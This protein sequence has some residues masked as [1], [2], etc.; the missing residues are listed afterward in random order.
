MDTTETYR[1][2][3]DCPEIQSHQPKII[4]SPYGYVPKDGEL[5]SFFYMNGDIELLHYDNDTSCMMIGGYRDEDAESI[6]L[7]R[8]DQLQE[9]LSFVVGAF[10]DNF[11]SALDNLH[12]YAFTVPFKADIPVS[13]EQLWL[14][15]VMYE[16]HQKVWTGDGWR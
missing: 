16:L 3:A 6:W 4:G 7:P 12:K 11:W 15:F 5:G 1:K 14:A 2:M 9:M 13:M 10:Q 8:Q